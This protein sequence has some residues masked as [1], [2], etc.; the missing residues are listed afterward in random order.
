M[1]VSIINTN[2]ITL[3]YTLGKAYDLVYT[4]M[5]SGLAC[6]LTQSRADFTLGLC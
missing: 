4:E 1:F 5:L 2:Y 6:L 3:V